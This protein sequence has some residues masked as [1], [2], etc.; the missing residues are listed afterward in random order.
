MLPGIGKVNAGE[1]IQYRTAHG[2]FTSPDDL[3]KVK[4][5]GAKTVEKIR[6]MIIVQ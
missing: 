2:K 3:V 5:I 1:I 6:G 4:G